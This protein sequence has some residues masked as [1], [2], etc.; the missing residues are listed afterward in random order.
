MARRS[1][2]S[3]EQI[4]NMAIAEAEKIIVAEGPAALSAR[5]VTQAIGYSVGSLYL[6]FDN[7][8]DLIAHV[9]RRTVNGLFEAMQ[10]AGEGNAKPLTRLKRMGRAY[11]DYSREHPNRLRLAFEHPYP[12]ATPGQ[13]DRS[14][15]QLVGLVVAPLAEASGLSGKKL[16]TAA[17]VLWSGVHG[18]CILALTEK[19]ARVGSQ[20]RVELLTDSLIENYIGGLKA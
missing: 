1:D 8:D 15:E 13:N 6:V 12:A 4:K 2:H 19:M 20:T 17:Q 11:A 14:G 16:E 10:Q 3:R 7:L 18:I 9:N 5:R